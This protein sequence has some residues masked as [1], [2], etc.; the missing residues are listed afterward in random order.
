MTRSWFAQLPSDV[1][2]QL[3][4]IARERQLTT[5]EVLFHRGDSFDGIYLLQRGL[6]LISGVN[7][8]GNEA[9]LTVLEAGA[10]FGEIALFDGEPRTHD[11]IAAQPCQLLQFPALALQ[12]LLK[13]QPGYWQ[14]LGQLLT[15]KMRQV[16][17][18]MEQHTLLDAKARLYWRLLQLCPDDGA[19]LPLSQQ[20]LAQLL[21]ISRQSTNQLLQALARQGVIQLGYGAL[22]LKDRALLQQLLQQ[23]D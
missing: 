8:Q 14:W 11:A 2:Q 15:A 4:R 13:Q 18:A 1:Q 9:L 5:G 19:Y 23:L 6:I 22:E 17:A 7:R 20:Q 16:F 10:M 12:Q 21:G 3:Q